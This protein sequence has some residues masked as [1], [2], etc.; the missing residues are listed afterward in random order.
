MLID[1]K[2]Y[3]D[4]YNHISNFIASFTD[5]D[6]RSY[7]NTQPYPHGFKDNFLPEWFYN[8]LKNEVE[9]LPNDR[10][11]DQKFV[12]VR[13]PS[14][15]DKIVDDAKGLTL[16]REL[17]ENLT[18]DDPYATILISILYSSEFI[19]FLEQLSGMEP[20][21]PDPHLFGA[22][23]LKNSPP[24]ELAVHIDPTSHAKLHLIR[25]LNILIYFDNDNINGGSIGIYDSK[26]RKY[27]NFVENKGNRL[28]YFTQTDNAWHG[29]PPLQGDINSERIAFRLFYWS[30]Q[31]P[32]NIPIESARQ[33]S[34]NT[35]NG[36]LIE[37]ARV[38]GKKITGKV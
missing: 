29:Y 21:I 20:L 23:F 36:E 19:K 35:E 2:L 31:N 4:L 16:M 17:K 30:T 8:E 34:K 3:K 9:N 22:G 24:Y 13:P 28:V 7:Q 10:W 26:Q 5:D 33:L 15:S 12:T 37:Y 1:K 6:F 14:E 25:L 38:E 18:H 11:H 32:K 27:S